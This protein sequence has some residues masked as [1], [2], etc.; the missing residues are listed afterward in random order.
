[1]TGSGATAVGRPRVGRPWLV[2]VLVGVLLGTGLL[3]WGLDRLARQTVQALLAATLQEA[4]GTVGTPTV[5]VQ[6]GPVLLQALRGRY[7]EVEVTL[8]DVSNG[9]LTFGRV[10]AQLQGVHLSFHDLLVREADVVVFERS[11]AQ[12]WLGYDA[13]DRY[14][15]FT[16]RPMTVLPEGSGAA[17]EVRLTA[18]GQLLDRRYEASATA[19]VEPTTGALVVRPTEVRTE[20]QLDRTAARLLAARFRFRVPLDPLPFGSEVADFE[21]G[22]EALTVRTGGSGVVLRG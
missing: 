18:T 13:L 6:G 5:E 1:M 21:L 22:E 11:A 14:L 20:Q 2:A 19:V 17:D 10:E 7:G 16:G 12:A 3:L 4:T 8:E 15:Q 9:P